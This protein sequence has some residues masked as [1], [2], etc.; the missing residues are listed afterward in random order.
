MGVMGR[1]LTRRGEG[2]KGRSLLIPFAI[3][4]AGFLGILSVDVRFGTLRDEFVTQTIGWYLLAFVGF[5]GAIVVVERQKFVDKRWL[6]GGAILFRILLL[7][8]TPTLSDDVYRYLWDG[9]IANQGV[10]PYAYAIE[11]EVLDPYDHPIRQLANNTWMASPYM[12]T[13]Q[14][15]FRGL[16]TTLLITPLILQIAMVAFDLG[17]AFI[18]TKLLALA[19]LPSRRLLLYLW[20]PLVIVEVAHGAHVD[21]WMICLGMLAIYLTYRPTQTVATKTLAPILFAFSTLTKII[22]VL[23][24]PVLFWRWNWRQRIGYGLL[25]VGLLVPYGQR[26]GWGVSGELNGRGLFGALRIYSDQWKFNS[27][28]FHWLDFFLDKNP[29][30]VDAAA[31]S[32]QVVFIFIFGILVLVWL[33]AY[34]A[35]SVRTEFRLLFIPFTAYILLTPT[36]HPWYTLMMFTLLPFLPPA[37]DESWTKWLVVLPWLYLAGAIIFSYL[38]YRDP[39]AFAELTWVRRMEWLP[40]LLGAFGAGALLNSGIFHHHWD[41]SD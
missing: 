20:N 35:Q 19:K 2:A 31:T 41:A 28:I 37:K 33:Y 38:T 14:W 17:T 39:S 30:I 25:T 23:A 3:T 10:S 7:F 18:L 8:T 5:V 36:V 12:P 15:L 22:P 27:G 26:A 13:A 29:I 11:S 21:A 32:K 16:T 1:D 24:L 34:H 6:W 9:Y 4:L 40:T